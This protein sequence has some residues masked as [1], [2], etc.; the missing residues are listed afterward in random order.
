MCLVCLLCLMCL[1]GL[2]CLMCGVNYG[3]CPQRVSNRSCIVRRGGGGMLN[4]QRSKPGV[5]SCTKLYKPALFSSPFKIALFLH[6]ASY[7]LAL[8]CT[9]QSYT[10][11]THSPACSSLKTSDI[12]VTVHRIHSRAVFAPRGLKLKP[13]SAS[14]YHHPTPMVTLIWSFCQHRNRSRNDNII[15]MAASPLLMQ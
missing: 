1:V 14:N 9:L 8:F 5:E 10:N 6:F 7:K 15:F 4:A 13:Q 11:F 3:L 2:L 12:S